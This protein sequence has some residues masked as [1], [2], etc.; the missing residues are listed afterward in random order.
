[1]QTGRIASLSTD[2][3]AVSPPAAAPSGVG[4]NFMGMVA[5]SLVAQTPAET[6]FAAAATSLAQPV[7]GGLPLG[8]VEGEP[9][10]PA[11]PLAGIDVTETPP[12]LVAAREASTPEPQLPLQALPPA[13]SPIAEIGR[14][15]AC[16]QEAAKG[17][18]EGTPAVTVKSRATA[19]SRR[20]K[21]ITE[22]QDDGQAAM[23]ALPLVPVQI[24][25]AQ[26][27]ISSAGGATTPD[28]P[29]SVADSVAVPAPSVRE[30]G[31]R[32]DAVPSP[33]IESPAHS[34]FGD[35]PRTVEPDMGR[36]AIENVSVRVSVEALRPGGDAPSGPPHLQAP[37]AK[38]G[39]RDDSS[40]KA[41][42]LRNAARQAAVLNEQAPTSES[43]PPPTSILPD[44]QAAMAPTPPA[45]AAVA[46]APPIERRAQGQVVDQVAPAIA[47]LARSGESA[48]RL[49]VRLDPDS[50]GRV[51]IRIERPPEAPAR[52]VITAER[53]ETLS[54]LEHD[55]RG[56]EQALDRAGLSIGDASVRF[57]TAPLEPASTPSPGFSA[58]VGGG[59]SGAAGQGFAG[60]APPSQSSNRIGND[61]GE[62]ARR[63]P[64]RMVRAGIDIMA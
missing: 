55:R 59:D 38:V 44:I 9:K 20:E 32:P 53:P 10:V 29:I 51:E 40:A 64:A 46:D 30:P 47:T 50:L 24:V 13:D 15:F 43:P 41:P 1:M 12:P 57:H 48:H 5:L 61:S 6:P 2:M 23:G 45:N 28:A 35:L 62:P 22:P 33:T 16:G 42:S 36:V 37:Q 7:Q 49:I 26:A 21:D 11:I 52:I 19:A 18:S 8:S 63:E 25:A 56:L 39:V 31:A 60:R 4:P 17:D 14:K 3:K 54:L 58:H 27:V 34:E